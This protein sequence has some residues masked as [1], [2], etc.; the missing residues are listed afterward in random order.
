HLRNM[1]TDFVRETGSAWGQEILDN[2]SE[3]LSKFWLVKPKAAEITSL[4]DSLV[5]KAA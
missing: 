4:L 2:Y 5:N 1:I 3:F